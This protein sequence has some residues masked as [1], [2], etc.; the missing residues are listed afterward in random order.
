MD[1]LTQNNMNVADGTSFLT[2]CTVDF[3]NHNSETSQMAQGTRPNYATQFSFKNRVDDFYIN[4]LN[5]NTIKIDIY[6]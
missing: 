6:L 4:Y 3:Y 5:K 2:L 1:A